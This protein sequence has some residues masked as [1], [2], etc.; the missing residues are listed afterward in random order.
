MKPSSRIRNDG[1][2]LASE[3]RM[4]P[5]AGSLG[6]LRGAER[7]PPADRCGENAV[8]CSA[9]RGVAKAPGGVFRQLARRHESCPRGNRRQ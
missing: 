4:A 2:G 1:G 5:S 3:G 8:D 9:D 7:C 6:L